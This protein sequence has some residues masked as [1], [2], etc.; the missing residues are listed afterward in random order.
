MTNRLLLALET[1]V[2]W[3]DTQHTPYMIFGG[4]ANSFYGNPRQTFDIDVKISVPSE[5]DKVDFIEQLRKIAVVLPAD[6]MQ[7]IAE[8]SVL[9][10]TLHEVRI[11]LVF[12]QL[13]FE[14]RAI[15]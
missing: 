1:I 11:D 5:N 7:F 12:A 13:P 14:E 6:P 3:F 4:I 8:T 10:V 2:N 15:K 9:P